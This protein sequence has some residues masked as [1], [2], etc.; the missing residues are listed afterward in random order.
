MRTRNYKAD[1]EELEDG[2]EEAREVEFDQQFRDFISEFVQVGT[3]HEEHNSL[4]PTITEDD[5]QGFLDS[6][7]FPDVDEWCASEY[8]SRR[9]SFEDAKY[10]EMKDERMGL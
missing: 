7:D 1:L 9:D 2:Y 5:I 10:E 4:L 3:I 6:F 8:E